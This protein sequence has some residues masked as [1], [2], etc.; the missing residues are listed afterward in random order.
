MALG[1]LIIFIYIYMRLFYERIPTDITFTYNFWLILLYTYIVIINLCL[2]GLIQFIKSLFPEKKQKNKLKILKKLKFLFKPFEE[3]INILLN[4]QMANTIFINI[5]LYYYFLFKPYVIT[6]Y[7]IFNIIPRIVIA[8]ALFIDIYNLYFHYFYKSL[9]LILI[10]VTYTIGMTLSQMML[11]E[12]LKLAKNTFQFFWCFNIEDIKLLQSL[13]FEKSFLMY[14]WANP[15]DPEEKSKFFYLWKNIYNAAIFNKISLLL[16]KNKTIKDINRII[17]F[18]FAL[19]WWYILFN[20][21]LN[22]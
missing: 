16:S 19:E 13:N 1:I 17:Y 2:A 12:K 5:T 7:I 10:P 6:T 14:S 15:Q 9:V 20:M 8:L 11:L 3:I 18:I 4:S 22:M 21:L